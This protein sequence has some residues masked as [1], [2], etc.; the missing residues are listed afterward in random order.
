MY[1]Q[2][3]LSDVT[4]LYLCRYYEILDEMIQYM[5]KAQ[6]TDSVSHNFIVQ[7]IPHH[8]AAVEMSRNILR[9]TTLVPLQEIALNIIEE[10][11]KGISDMRGILNQCGKMLNSKKD[12]CLYQKGFA[13]ISQTMFSKMENACITNNINQDFMREMIPHHEGAICMSENALRYMICPQL[14]PI[15][16][17]IIKTQR[18]GVCKME[19]LLACRS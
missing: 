16:H 7:M 14:A 8:E 11:R 19:R 6:L 15:L 12:L 17:R 4:K 5:T 13:Q 3:R 2:E 18:E 1:G 10:Q 9:Y